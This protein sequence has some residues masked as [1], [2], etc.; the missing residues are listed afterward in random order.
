M[1]N[2]QRKSNQKICAKAKKKLGNKCATALI[3]ASGMKKRNKED[4][5]E[6]DI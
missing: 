5:M 2:S 1:K 3:R 6:V 4:N